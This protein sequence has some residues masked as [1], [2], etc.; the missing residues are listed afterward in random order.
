MDMDSYAKVKVT[1][2]PNVRRG[3]NARKPSAV[4]S[5]TGCANHSHSALVNRPQ[6]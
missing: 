1:K 5:T 2:D 3:K 4:A 6:I